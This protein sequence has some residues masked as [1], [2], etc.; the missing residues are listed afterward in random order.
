MTTCPAPRATYTAVLDLFPAPESL[1]AQQTLDLALSWIADNP[2]SWDFIVAGAQRDAL[3]GVPIRIKAYVEALR[4]RRNVSWATR[5]VK[6]PNG[7]TPAF[8][9]IL[10]EWY[11]ELAP[12]IRLAS[13]KLNGLVIPPRRDVA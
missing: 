12:S 7:L 8:G 4:D 1:T 2:D 11:P 5:A 13:S 9:R 10:V 6:L 3:D